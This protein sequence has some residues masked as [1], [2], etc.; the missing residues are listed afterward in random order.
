MGSGLYCSY[1]YKHYVYI[2]MKHHGLRDISLSRGIMYSEV[3]TLK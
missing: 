1:M 3:G 2:G